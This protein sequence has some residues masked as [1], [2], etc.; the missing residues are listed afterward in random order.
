[1][2][3]L[4]YIVNCILL[5]TV[6]ATSVHAQHIG[7]A[8]LPLLNARYPVEDVYEVLRES[9]RPA[10][11]ILYGTFGKSSHN[12]DLLLERM[13][14]HHSTWLAP[15]RVGVYVT[16]G[17]CRR[18]RRDGSLEHFAS[19]LTISEFNRVIERPNRGKNRVVLNEYRKRVRR[20]LAL[21]NKW[22]AWPIEWRIFPELEDNLS[23]KARRVLTNILR[24]EIR[25][26]PLNFAWHVAINPLQK[27][28]IPGVPLEVHSAS[29]PLANTLLPGDAVSFD[30]VDEFPSQS[31]LNA[32]KARRAD[33]L[34]WDF[35]MQQP[36]RPIKDRKFTI[37][38]KPR[39][40]ALMRGQVIP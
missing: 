12:L 31:L 14:S 2:R 39:L 20:V 22:G 26:H 18:P 38:N 28:R 9:K 10:I 36:N 7:L 16:C 19:G 27:T 40:K 3:L 29:V 35:A 5:C 25:A 4:Y 13:V 17:P 33:Y 32:L 15:L 24:E 37:Q 34:Y 11:N 1:M 6:M 23:A 30:G 21:S 8:A